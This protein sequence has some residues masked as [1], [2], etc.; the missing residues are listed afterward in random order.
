VRP[1]ARLDHEIACAQSKDNPVARPVFVVA[2]PMRWG[3]FESLLTARHYRFRVRRAVSPAYLGEHRQERETR[4][5]S[6]AAYVP[7][8]VKEPEGSACGTA[9]HRRASSEVLAVQR[10]SIDDAGLARDAIAVLAT[11]SRTVASA[12]RRGP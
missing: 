7:K 4:R 10:P 5:S 12:T 1:D 6:E 8:G 11:P 2:R 9:D 3:G